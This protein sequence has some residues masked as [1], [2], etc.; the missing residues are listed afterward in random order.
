MTDTHTDF[1]NDVSD[2]ASESWNY[3]WNRRGDFIELAKTTKVLHR[4]AKMSE[5]EKGRGDECNDFTRQMASSHA[6][7]ALVVAW[8]IALSAIEGA[9]REVSAGQPVTLAQLRDRMIAVAPWRSKPGQET[10]SAAQR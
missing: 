4:F 8:E 1:R 10:S 5:K 3:L 2:V 7:A 6:Q 9:E